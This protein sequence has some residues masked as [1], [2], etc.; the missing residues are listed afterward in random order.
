[1][2]DIYTSDNCICIELR[3]TI[4]YIIYDS[5]RIHILRPQFDISSNMTVKNRTLVEFWLEKLHNLSYILVE[6]I[7]NKTRFRIVRSKHYHAS[8]Y[9]ALK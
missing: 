7:D 5:D 1:M 4:L 2:Y 6:Y 3:Y 9:Y 8:M